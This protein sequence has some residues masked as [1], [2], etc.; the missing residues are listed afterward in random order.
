MARQNRQDTLQE[1]QFALNE[2]A[3]NSELANQALKRQTAQEE[4][5]IKNKPIPIDS[6]RG[7]FQTPAAADYAQKLATAM[8]AVE[9]IGGVQIIRAGTTKEIYE[10]L[11]DPQHMKV[12]GNLNIRHYRNQIGQLQGQLNEMQQGG[13]DL[14]NDKKAMTIAQQ[15]KQ[16]QQ[17]LL[18]SL[19]ETD[20]VST[21]MDLIE[22]GYDVGKVQQAMQSGDMSVLGEPETRQGTNGYAPTMLAKLIAERA[23][24]AESL[25]P[26]HPTIKAYDN[27]IS[28]TDIDIDN[29][30]DDEI[31]V[32]GGYFNLT[33][34]MP[35]LG[36]GK[37]STAIRVKIVK[38]AA[39]QALSED[40]DAP[41][42][43]GN[44]KPSDAA[45][46]I[47]SKQ[48]DTKSIQGAMNFL[49][50][51]VGA[52]GSFVKNIDLQ[53]DKVGELA[54]ELKTFD[55]RLLNVP[56]RAVRGRVAGS[57][58]QAKYDL[59]LAEI[60]SE[61]GKLATGSAASIAELSATA[62]E[63]WAKIHDKNLSVKDMLELL[64]ETRNAAYMRQ[65]SVV[66]QLEETRTKMRTRKPSANKNSSSLKVGTVMDGYRFKGGSP[67]DK[68]NW[69][70]AE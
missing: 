64:E 57:P 16:A 34:K 2:K 36:R 48:A 17:G 31:D 66:D 25:P 59:Y 18:G 4:A 46:D 51:Q 61:I 29:M 27:K 52:M 41:E 67:S 43:E 37:Q 49:E 44:T 9:D 58:L 62:Q 32:L 47:V 22:Q 38:S 7:V 28:G 30:S 69:E 10:V 55:T 14:S 11:N 56:L 60:E 24:L 45:L 50:K 35:S 33:G 6:I 70:K 13:K 63:R 20:R 1:K 3:V 40:P 21:Y 8:G 5:K 26:D 12:I 23:K 68:S 39:R 65:K 15:L 19:E 42:V 53:V 54:D